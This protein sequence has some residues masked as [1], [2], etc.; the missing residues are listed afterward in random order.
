MAGN[1]SWV[2]SPG[3]PVTNG[4][5]PASRATRQLDVDVLPDWIDRLFGA[6]YALCGSPEDAEDLVQ[7]TCLR[8]LRRPRLLRRESEGAYLMRALRNTWIDTRRS[9]W[10]TMERASIQEL[11]LVAAPGTD[12]ATIADAH[13][14]YQAVTRLSAPLRATIVAVDVLGLSYKEAARALGTP[15]GTIMSR[16]YRAR[17]RVAASLGDLE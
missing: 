3:Q 16:L 14:A 7:E 8:V 17:Q 2:R 4:A 5:S 15:E 10:S 1:A 11:D 13:E 9:R 6:A 12:A